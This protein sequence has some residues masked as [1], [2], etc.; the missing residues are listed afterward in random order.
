MADYSY[1]KKPPWLTFITSTLSDADQETIEPKTK[2]DNEE[3]II[4]GLK[5]EMARAEELIDTLKAEFNSDANGQVDDLEVQNSNLLRLCK[6]GGSD[7]R[8]NQV[9]GPNRQCSYQ[10]RNHSGD[11][12]WQRG[13]QTQDGKVWVLK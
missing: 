2:H 11:R 7:R 1:G 4:D 8:S 6:S 5:N 13:I 12:G 10:G 9:I 3:L